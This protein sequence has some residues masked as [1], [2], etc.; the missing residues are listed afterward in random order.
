[1]ATSVTTTANMGLKSKNMNRTLHTIGSSASGIGGDAVAI[2]QHHGRQHSSVFSDTTSLSKHSNKLNR[3]N[4]SCSSGG[5]KNSCSMTLLAEAAFTATA[6]S[7]PAPASYEKN[8]S[9]PSLQKQAQQRHEKPEQGL[10]SSS[11]INS[12]N[13]NSTEINPTPI[14]KNNTTKSSRKCLNI[15]SISQLIQT[16]NEYQ[17]DP[18]KPLGITATLVNVW[19]VWSVKPNSQAEE[20]GILSGD[21]LLSVGGSEMNAVPGGSSS[22]NSTKIPKSKQPSMFATLKSDN[23]VVRAMTK[24]RDRSLSNGTYMKLV[25]R[26]RSSMRLEKMD[27]VLSHGNNKISMDTNSILSNANLAIVPDNSSSSNNHH[28]KNSINNS[29]PANNDNA[30]SSSIGNMEQN[31]YNSGNHERTSECGGDGGHK[32]D[33]VPR[34]IVDECPLQVIN[35]EDIKI[36][37]DCR[38]VKVCSDMCLLPPDRAFKVTDVCKL[39]FDWLKREGG[40]IKGDDLHHYSNYSQANEENEQID[41]HLLQHHTGAP[42]KTSHGSIHGIM[43]STG[44]NTNT[45]TTNM[46]ETNNINKHNK[47]NISKNTEEGR[48]WHLLGC[49]PHLRGPQLWKLTRSKIF[50]LTRSM[51]EGEELDWI[52]TIDRLD[53]ICTKNR[54]RIGRYLASWNPYLSEEDTISSSSSSSS[55]TKSKY[56][57]RQQYVKRVTMAFRQSIRKAIAFGLSL[58]VAHTITEAYV[59]M[60]ASHFETMNLCPKI[61]P[62][63]MEQQQTGGGGHSSN[64]DDNNKYASS[65]SSSPTTEQQSK[66]QHHQQRLLDDNNKYASSSSSSPT[67]EQQ[68]KQQH[69][70]QRLL[71]QLT[72]PTELKSTILKHLKELRCVTLPF[73]QH[74]HVHPSN[75]NSNTNRNIQKSNISNGNSNTSALL[76]QIAN[77]VMG[78]VMRNYLTVT[79]LH[80]IVT[81]D[82]V[83]SILDDLEDESGYLSKMNGC[84]KVRVKY[85]VV[86]KAVKAAE[87]NIA[88]ASKRKAMAEAAAVAAYEADVKAAV[89]KRKVQAAKAA[90]LAVAEEKARRIEEAKL[91]ASAE[92]ERI[93][94]EE[95][96]RKKREVAAVAAA[97]EELK[98]RDL[99]EK[100]H[101][102]RKLAEAREIERMEREAATLAAAAEKLRREREAAAVAATERRRER[103][104]T[105][106][107]AAGEELRRRVSMEKKYC[108][109]TT[110]AAAATAAATAAAINATAV[111]AAAE[112]DQKQKE[113]YVAAL[114]AEEE[115]KKKRKRDEE[116][117]QQRSN[118]MRKE[119]KLL[120]AEGETAAAPTRLNN[121]REKRVRNTSIND[122]AAATVAAHVSNEFLYSIGNTSANTKQGQTYNNDDESKMRMEQE[123]IN[124]VIAKRQK[125]RSKLRSIPCS[126][127][128]SRKKKKR[129]HRKSQSGDTAE[130]EESKLRSSSS[131]ALSSASASNEVNNDNDGNAVA[132]DN[133]HHTAEGEEKIE[134]FSV[135]DGVLDQQQQDGDNDYRATAEA[136]ED[137]KELLVPAIPLEIN[138]DDDDNIQQQIQALNNASTPT[139][140]NKKKKKRKKKRSSS[141]KTA[142]GETASAVDNEEV[143]RNIE[144]TKTTAS[145]DAV[146]SESNTVEQVQQQQLSDDNEVDTDARMYDDEE[147]ED[148]VKTT[149]LD[150]NISVSVEK[151]DNWDDGSSSR[152]RSSKNT[153]RQIKKNSES[154]NSSRANSPIPNTNSTA[155]TRRNSPLRR[156]VTS[157]VKTLTVRAADVAK[158]AAKEKK[159]KRKAVDYDYAL[160]EEEGVTIAKTSLEPSISIG[161]TITAN[162][163]NSSSVKEVDDLVEDDDDDVHNNSSAV[164]K[165]LRRLKKKPTSSNNRAQQQQQMNQNKSVGTR[166]YA[167]YSNGAFYWGKVEMES[168]NKKTREYVYMVIFEDGDVLG[169]INYEQVLTEDDFR[170]RF[171]KPPPSPKV[172]KNR[173]PSRGSTG[174]RSSVRTDSGSRQRSGRRT[175][176]R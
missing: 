148:G 24:E 57:V 55:S 54:P 128:S 132:N 156:R 74:H 43:T 155:S 147:E 103:E 6:V 9:W 77:V 120:D 45:V 52:C 101:A 83:R 66:Q 22:E 26:P 167:R 169:N 135:D 13:N 17:I 30:S 146:A 31:N 149:D 114:E 79:P 96:C 20:L 152:G 82:E 124:A 10:Y 64:S 48:L 109:A 50:Y 93:L 35:L 68:S 159:K 71:R 73:L 136:V 106:L 144:T 157:P 172:D 150:S 40:F 86:M 85:S 7:G 4:S 118:Y 92:A 138:D 59:H 19:H 163:Q 115:E 95:E 121:S 123:Q 166:V 153:T 32:N 91:A 49:K 176:R 110:A 39:A 164:S 139:T 168:I 12:S 90:A 116:N 46:K 125:S 5:L 27:N 18:S 47:N 28:A 137:E 99:M 2:S 84:L 161:S 42:L 70:Q 126:N 100:E 37:L 98:R 41:Q 175:K 122:A 127:N 65:S 11:I 72:S 173:T 130:S 75:K 141:G 102:V 165:P 67:T 143:T 51:L 63:P 158:V 33:S 97:A 105:A 69:H 81:I 23:E 104:A 78:R 174:D 1:M 3:I 61:P 117:M 119:Q 15:T 107:A 53:D 133:D 76:D 14:S 58:G 142:T 16:Q 171:N 170:A 160:S 8:A 89:V 88:A 111:T 60:M 25:T 56:E 134:V 62:Q 29:A 36:A 87:A 129:D 140:T 94:L 44:T 112:E 145:F 113:A 162:S 21:A 131:F 151:T 154:R 34:E 80:T 108:A 38:V